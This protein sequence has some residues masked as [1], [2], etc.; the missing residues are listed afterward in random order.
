MP[1]MKAKDRDST[2]KF[3]SEFFAVTPPVRVGADQA[4]ASNK[5]L[6]I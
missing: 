6:C 5:F 3:F 2:A 4:P 1:K